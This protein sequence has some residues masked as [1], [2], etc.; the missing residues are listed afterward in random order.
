MKRFKIDKD[1][2]LFLAAVFF[3]AAYTILLSHSLW[4]FFAL[5]AA[6][7]FSTVA[8]FFGPDGEMKLLIF[9]VTVII[10]VAE[11]IYMTDP[12]RMEKAHEEEKR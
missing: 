11:A 12:E 3:T 6:E 7:T 10:L 4:P 1:A 2:W 9:I 5:A 8:S